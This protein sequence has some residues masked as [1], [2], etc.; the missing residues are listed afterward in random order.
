MMNSLTATR[1]AEFLSLSSKGFEEIRKYAETTTLQ[2]VERKVYFRGVIEFSNACEKDCYYCGIRNSNRIKRYC[3]QKKEIIETALKAFKQGYGSIVLQSGELTSKKNFDFML[4]TVSSVKKKSRELDAK[5]NG[6]GITLSLGELSK[7]RL[8]ELFEAGAHRYLLRIETSNKK[9]YKQLHPC[10][11]K[12]S[13]NKRIKC[14]QNLKN[15][16]FQVGTGT[17]IGLPEQGVE[18]LAKD[19]LFFKE[20]DFDMFGIGP[21]IIHKDTPVGKQY[22]KEWQKKKE[23]IFELSLRMISLLR[24][25]VNDANIASTTA[26]QAMHSQ[27][28]ELGLL[29]GANIVMPNITP[30]KYRAQY[31]LYEGKPCIEENAE[32]CMN[33]LSAR[34]KNIGRTPVLQEW[35]DS[36]HYFNRT[37]EKR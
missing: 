22:E 19:L 18:D 17:M 35:G 24:I 27:G 14:L 16:G 31:L 4:N 6:I 8:Q 7:N 37:G 21:Y 23:R 32:D 25:L 15:I 28:R 20:H 9:L 29:Y 33:C 30:Q 36:L 34:I 2:N 3:M 13:F 10:N 12:H 5:D 1:L 26:L 11:G